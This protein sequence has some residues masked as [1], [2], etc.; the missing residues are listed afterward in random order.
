MEEPTRRRIVEY[1]KPLAVGL[2]GMTYSGDVER[3]ASICR[4]IAA[5][6]QDVDA[7]LL[8]LMAIF[9][10][11]EKWVERMGHASRTEIFLASLGIPTATIRA[12]FRGLSRLN[13]APA[14]AE[15][16]I[17]HDALRIDEMGAIGVARLAQQGYRERLSFE[18]MA[19][20][21][22]EAA[23][24][25]LKTPAGETLAGQ[26]RAIMLEFACRLREEHREFLP[27]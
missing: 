18:E 17:V 15:E 14:A 1:V 11:Q 23:R 27:A 3:V 7:E 20:V 13:R 26:R 10:G 9:S 16:D 8:D 5:G 2:D 6:R 19:D 24:L 25:P 12:L 4:R 22:E 21:I